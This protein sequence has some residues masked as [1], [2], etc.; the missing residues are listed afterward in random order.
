MRIAGDVYAV[1]TRSFANRGARAP[2]GRRRGL[3]GYAP[4]PARPRDQGLHR[5]VPRLSLLFIPE[6]FGAQRIGGM[7]SE[8][9]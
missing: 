4:P 5:G 9:L 1:E 7:A 6:P 3:T 2:H 8:D